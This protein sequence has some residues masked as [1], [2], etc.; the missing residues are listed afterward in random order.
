MLV[1]MLRDELGSEDGVTLLPYKCGVEY[2]LGERLAGIF[3]RGGI[4]EVVTADPAPAVAVVLEP[5]VCKVVEPPRRAAAA[6]PAKA[7]KPPVRKGTKA[8]AR[9]SK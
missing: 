6:P 3:V 2:E 7:K 9:Q 1:R 4:A 5:E 8:K